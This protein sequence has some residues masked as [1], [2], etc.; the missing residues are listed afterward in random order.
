VEEA[1]GKRFIL[2]DKA[3]WIREVAVNLK[4]QF[5]EYKIRSKEISYCPIK[6][7]SFFS[8]EVKLL[9][10][11]WRRVLEIDNRQSREILGIE[12]RPY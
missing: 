10:P 12:Y 9:I 8:S 7:A 3:L 5:P 11:M 6:M 1:K 2:G 4:E